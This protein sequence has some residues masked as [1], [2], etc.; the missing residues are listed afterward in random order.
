ML[1][2]RSDTRGWS[3]KPPQRLLRFDTI[4]ARSQ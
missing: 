2:L 4:L 1:L 3:G